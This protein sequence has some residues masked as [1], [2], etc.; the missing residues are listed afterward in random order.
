MVWRD[1]V[2]TTYREEVIT[3]IV[4]RVVAVYCDGCGE[5]IPELY[6]YDEREVKLW[7][8]KGS[9]YPDGGH[10]YGWQVEDLCDACVEKLE[11]LVRDAGFNVTPYEVDW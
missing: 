8:A 6:T 2:T 9:A 3:Q 10:L 7:Y 4:K 11:R 1:E 5:E